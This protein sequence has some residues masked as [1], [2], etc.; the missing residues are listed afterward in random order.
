MTDGGPSLT[1][2][3][4]LWLAK[5]PLTEDSQLE[6]TG[7]PYIDGK[8][9]LPIVSNSKLLYERVSGRVDT[10]R[11]QIAVLGLR[12]KLSRKVGDLPN[13]SRGGSP[14]GFWVSKK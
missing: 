7:G 14:Q 12:L 2:F 13:G 8:S 5:G 6:A 4:A 11:S 10:P 9:L 3:G 1:D